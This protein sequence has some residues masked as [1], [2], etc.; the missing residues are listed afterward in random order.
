MVGRQTP[1]LALFVPLILVGMVDGRRGVQGRLAGRAGRRP[2]LR[3]RPVRVLELLLGRADRHRRL[4]AV[5]RRD[6]RLP[7]RLAA[8]R[9]AGRR[10]RRPAR[11]GDRRRRDARRRATRRRS[12]AARA[13][14]ATHAATS[15]ARL[16]AVRDHHRRPRAR[17]VGSDQ[18]L[19]GQ[20]RDQEFSWPGLDILNAKGEAPSAVTF[21]FNW[22][23][24][25]GT[26]LLHLRPADDARPARLAR[27]RALRAYGHMLDQLKWATLTVA[28]VLGARLRDEPVGA[29]ADDRHLDRRRRRRAR[30]LLAD[31]RLA[32]R[33]RSP[34]RTRRRTR[35]SACCR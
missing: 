8:R 31:H 19:P 10:G 23:P 32:R 20:G 24:A 13:R 34:A 35:S 12:D 5:G 18:G 21:K 25:A 33:R 22:L 15:I 30:L 7:A 1:M 4:A 3:D 9:P 2:H 14:A 26:L 11:A 6:G 17:A 27:G 29:D 28:A 16:R